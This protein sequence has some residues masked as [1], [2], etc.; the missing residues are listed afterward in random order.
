M[1]K[2]LPSVDEAPTSWL[3]SF[4]RNCLALVNVGLANQNFNLIRFL[5]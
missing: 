4:V 5:R 2:N 1:G 3:M